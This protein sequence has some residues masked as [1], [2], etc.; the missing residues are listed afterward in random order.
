MFGS[1]ILHVTQT[2][3]TNNRF[4]EVEETTMTKMKT[5]LVVQKSRIK[6]NLKGKTLT[7]VRSTIC[8]NKYKTAIAKIPQK[9]KTKIK[10][11]RL[12]STGYECTKNKPHMLLQQNTKTG[13]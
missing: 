3:S 1:E 12:D 8:K 5:K 10:L 6:S 13:K 4:L 2:F 9:T 7:E 11:R